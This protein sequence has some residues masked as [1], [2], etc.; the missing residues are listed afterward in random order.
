MAK[1]EETLN[2]YEA[3]FTK[4]IS[5]NA[6]G[7]LIIR[8]G[9]QELSIEVKNVGPYKFEVDNAQQL[10]KMQS[11]DSGIYHYK[12]DEAQNLWKSTSQVHFLDELLVREFITHSKGLLDLN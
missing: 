3:A 1:I 12:W 4:L 7:H 9:D 5:Q 10:L 11:A 2:R 6:P 8:R